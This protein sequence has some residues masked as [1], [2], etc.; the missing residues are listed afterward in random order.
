MRFFPL[1]SSVVEIFA[2]LPEKRWK[3]PALRSGR[4]KP[5]DCTSNV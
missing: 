1:M 2:S 5:A 3:S 4:F